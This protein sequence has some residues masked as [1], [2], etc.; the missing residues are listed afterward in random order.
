MAAPMPLP[1]P[2]TRAVLPA[3]PKSTT[4]LNSGQMQLES[5]LQKQAGL[6]K[7]HDEG[8]AAFREKRDAKFIGA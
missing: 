8:V 6:T 4:L 2:V 5:D 1:A 3:I 7:D